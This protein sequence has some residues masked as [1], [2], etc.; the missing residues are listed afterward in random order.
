M[1]IFLDANLIFSAVPDGSPSRQFIVVL[2]KKA[3][4]VSHPLVWEEAERNLRVKRPAWLAGLAFLQGCVALRAAMA[5]CPPRLLPDKDE[6]V[7]GAAIAS[8]CDYLVT[9]DRTHFGK[10]YGCVIHGVTIVSPWMLA[11]TM[12]E[13][14]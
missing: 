9:G 4:L 8:Q 1:R 11:E 7:L 13:W 5:V 14:R 3:E 6:P 10:L 2:G 12:Q